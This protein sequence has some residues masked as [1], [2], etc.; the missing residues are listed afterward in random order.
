MRASNSETA[1]ASPSSTDLSWQGNP[2]L[3]VFFH[4]EFIAALDSRMSGVLLCSEVQPWHRTG[5]PPPLI[6]VKFL[7]VTGR[8]GRPRR[9]LKDRQTDME[10]ETGNGG[11]RLQKRSKT[12]TR[13]P[14][15]RR[16]IRMPS[17]RRNGIKRKNSAEEKLRRLKEMEETIAQY[18]RQARTT[19]GE[20]SQ[21]MR[22]NIL[23]AR[24]RLW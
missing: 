5:S 3:I 22:S 7:T 24:S 15:Q 11:R 4:D 9:P 14:R 8:R 21:R 23:S 17:P 10:K 2:V 18:E 20:Q 12:N 6:Y 13:P 1:G 16:L 19:I